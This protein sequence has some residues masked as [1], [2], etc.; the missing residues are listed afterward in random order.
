MQ[1]LYDFSYG[2]KDLGQVT[3]QGETELDCQIDARAKIMDN[4]ILF[5]LEQESFHYSK[6]HE[7][8][9]NDRR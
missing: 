3:G 9:R 1:K 4:I 7:R 2:C 5:D 6:H 8:I